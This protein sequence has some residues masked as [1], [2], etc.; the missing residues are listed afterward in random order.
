MLQR[1]LRR[2]LFFDNFTS[3]VSEN[4]LL[5]QVV[6]NLREKVVHFEAD[7]YKLKEAKEKVMETSREREKSGLARDKYEVLHVVERERSTECE[8]QGKSSRF[9]ASAERGRARQTEELSQF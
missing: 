9:G 2:T 8:N 4:E 3:E 1:E 6:I 5:R 7:V